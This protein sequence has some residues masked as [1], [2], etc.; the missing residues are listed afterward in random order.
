MQYHLA[1]HAK[2]GPLV[3]V[4]PNHVSFSS[5]S[6]IHLVYGISS[7]F[8]KSNFYTLFDIKDPRTGAVVPT[9]FSVRDEGHHKTI[10]RS[11][12]AA[13]SMGTMRELEPM[14]DACSAILSAKL[15]GLV[16][17]DEIDLGQWV[18]W[19][20]FD[21][22]SSIT[23]SRRL[24]FLEEERDINGIIRAIEGRLVYN[25][26][27][28]QVPALHGWLFGS[29]A[30]AWLAGWVPCVKALNSSGF[31]VAF[32]AR[33]LERYQSNKKVE[34]G[35]EDWEMLDLLDRFKRF[36][37]GLQVMDDHELLSHC[38]SNIF[39]GSDTTA[40][41]LRA[42][43]YYLCR[44]PYA[45]TKLLTE[46]DAAEQEGIISDPITFAEAQGLV[47]FQAVIK[48]ALRMHP[49]VGLL[50][51]RLVP[52]GGVNLGDIWLPEGTI[53]GMN[54]WVA[55]RDTAVYGADAYEFRPER[56]LEADEE[57]LK[58]MER[59]FLAFGAGPRTCLG[60]NISLLEISKVVPQ[61]LRQFDF[62]LSH[63]EKEWKLYDYWFV[64]QT[65]LICRVIKRKK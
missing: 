50:L 56:W 13:Y 24:G 55:A 44:Y 47:Y 40:A 60:K 19:Y 32:A 3:R 2:Y 26:I 30:V 54:P 17:Q 16:G 35:G 48:E 63:P 45:K 58:L 21:V 65:G 4:G 51:E 12:A 52:H 36:K 7:K 1:L 57:H 20:A 31:I 53:V 34:T 15:D 28:G 61:L 39:A 59:S 64:R 43:F 46:I 8:E 62:Q 5:P 22:I 10:K 25:S 11:V 9:I 27:I 18:H 14:N 41:S 33:Q 23:F 29:R 42:I 38:A 37:D 6:L 49:A